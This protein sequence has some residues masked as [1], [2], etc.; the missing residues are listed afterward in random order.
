ML[1]LLIITLLRAV[2]VIDEKVRYNKFMNSNTIYLTVTAAIALAGYLFTYWNN[3][4]MARHQARLGLVNERLNKFYGP[5]YIIVKTINTSYQAQLVKAGKKQIY[6]DGKALSKEEWQ[7][8]HAWVM[9]VYAPLEQSLSDLIIQN[10][11]LIQEKNVSEALLKLVAHVSVT[12][13]LIYKWNKEDFTE[14]Y[15]TI[16]FPYEAITEYAE[17]SI[18][19]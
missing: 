2:I 1:H 7:E 11:H 16:D 12:Q 3:L 6:Q 17:R 5:L 18:M 19:S 8:H 9:A 14:L 4:R 15:P 13:A 10:A